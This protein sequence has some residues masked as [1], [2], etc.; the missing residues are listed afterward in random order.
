MKDKNAFGMLKQYKAGRIIVTS[1]K[2]NRVYPKKELK[3]V[4]ED[5]EIALPVKA[6][7][8][9]AVKMAD[10]NDLVLVTG[11]LYTAGEALEY[12]KFRTV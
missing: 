11:S 9:K 6:A 12:F 8:K 5:Y 1:P 10:K 7:I 4:F 2:S 3:R